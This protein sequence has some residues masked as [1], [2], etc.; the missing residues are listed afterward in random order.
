MFQQDII[1]HTLLYGGGQIPPAMLREE[2]NM[3]YPGPRAG[4]LE[5]RGVPMNSL[6]ARRCPAQ[7][8]PSRSERANDLETG[9]RTTE[10]ET[11]ESVAPA[12]A[13]P[14]LGNSSRSTTS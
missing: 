6:L 13:L 4:S 12:V 1:D 3:R 7:D 2:S 10:T 11:S 8:A 9:V 5:T 14:L